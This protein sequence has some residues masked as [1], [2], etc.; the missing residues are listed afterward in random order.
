MKEN[1][2]QT[3]AIFSLLVQSIFDVGFMAAPCLNG[4]SG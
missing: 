4:G 3:V 2:T 1:D